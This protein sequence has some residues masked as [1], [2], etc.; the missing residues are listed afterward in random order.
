MPRIAAKESDVDD[1]NELLTL[2]ARACGYEFDGFGCIDSG[3]GLFRRDAGGVWNPAEDPGDGAEMEDKL[4]IS[5]DRSSKAVFCDAI[6][7]LELH[8]AE[9]LYADHHDEGTARRWAS[10]RVAAAIGRGMK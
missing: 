7:N 4:R 3:C 6:W 10:L 2:A 9:E 5:V 1:L 8:R